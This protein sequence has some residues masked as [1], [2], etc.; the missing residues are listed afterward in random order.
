MLDS[1]PKLDGLFVSWCDPPAVQVADT[2]E[3]Q[4]RND[5]VITT[6]G[7]SS[8]TVAI[9]NQGGPIKATGAQFPYQQGIIEANMVGHAL[10]GN[11]TPPYI[12]SGSLPIYKGN[13]AK[14]YEKYYQED[15]PIISYFDRKG[16]VS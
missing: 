4:R 9:M 14:Q 6:T 1:N 8:R 13:L 7:L 3:N 15:F 12:A 5:V 2:V 11:K 10:L 16:G